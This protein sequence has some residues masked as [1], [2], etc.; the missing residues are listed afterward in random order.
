[1]PTVSEFLEN[2]QSGVPPALQS[3]INKV[4]GYANKSIGGAMGQTR[5]QGDALKDVM[6]VVGGLEKQRMGDES[7]MARLGVAGAQKT[8]LEQMQQTGATERTKIGVE[9]SMMREKRAGLTHPLTG[10]G[11]LG[12][13]GGSLLDSWDDFYSQKK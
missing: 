2:N 1:M 12:V 9:P 5:A 10:Q 4:T 7:A 13:G 6:G 11:G 3:I 8:G